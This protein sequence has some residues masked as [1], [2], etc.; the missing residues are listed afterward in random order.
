MNKAQDVD[1]NVVRGMQQGKAETPN[2][3]NG[4]K[5]LLLE[6]VHPDVS[7]QTTFRRLTGLSVLSSRSPKLVQSF[8]FP[9]TLK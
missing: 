8:P 3:D 2:S 6:A 5:S 7:T 9:L 1:T 4:T